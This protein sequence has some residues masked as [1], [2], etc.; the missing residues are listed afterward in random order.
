MLGT[1]V[2]RHGRR[3]E[4]NCTTSNLEIV[5]LQGMQ[6]TPVATSIPK[7]APHAAAAGSDSNLLHCQQVADEI[8][9]LEE[10][11]QASLKA[12]DHKRVKQKFKVDPNS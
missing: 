6:D 9:Y 2:H 10:C 7:P 12:D 11:Q 3:T 4:T 5:S 1:Q 8:H